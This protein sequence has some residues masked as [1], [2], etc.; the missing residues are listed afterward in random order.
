MISPVFP[1]DSQYKGGRRTSQ[2]KELCKNVI[3]GIYCIANNY[4]TNDTIISH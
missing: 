2:A 1:S 4:Q 3:F